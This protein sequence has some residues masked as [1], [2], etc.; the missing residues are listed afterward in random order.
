MRNLELEN[1]IDINKTK[2]KKKVDK[3]QVY[4]TPLGDRYTQNAVY[5]DNN[6][7]VYEELSSWLM[8]KLSM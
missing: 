5:W 8:I 4:Q 7:S 1:F 6:S 3:N 2:S